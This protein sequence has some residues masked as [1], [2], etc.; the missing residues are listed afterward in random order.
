MKEQR[1]LYDSTDNIKLCGLLS[2]V[3]DNNKIVVLCH[4]LKGDK[5]KEIVL[6]FLLKT[7]RTK[8]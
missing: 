3:N 4:G 8:H 6:M 5:Q 1:M 7:T 2:K